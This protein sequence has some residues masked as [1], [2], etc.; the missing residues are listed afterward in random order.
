MSST[1]LQILS[2]ICDK[3][4]KTTDNQYKLSF[5]NIATRSVSAVTLKSC[6]FKNVF[7]NVISS[8]LKLKNNVLYTRMQGVD[9]EFTVPEGFY[10]I[11]DLLT[12]LS[13]EISAFFL[14]YAQPLVL[15]DL[16]YNSITGKVSMT[17]SDPN[18]SNDIFELRGLDRP[19]SVN[20]LIGNTV[21]LSVSN[22]PLPKQLDS[23]INL[24]G[25]QCVNLVCE[26]ISK[27]SGSYVSSVNPNGSINNSIRT[28]TVNGGFGSP[29][30][31]LSRDT[32]ADQISY[33]PPINL[34]ALTFSITDPKTNAILDLSASKICIE[35]ILFF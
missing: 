16:S 15:D 33:N 8:N 19:D 26:P 6:S 4:N 34:S 32:D 25:Q 30:S 20:Y 35:L 23:L 7:Y 27:S 9:I 28:I 1:N 17:I 13:N 11:S 3:Q 12:V 29:V 14:L 21:N 18:L 31:Y 5:G 10:T 24:D 2:V 22:T